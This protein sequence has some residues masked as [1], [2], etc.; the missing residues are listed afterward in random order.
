[1][2]NSYNFEQCFCS[3]LQ[4]CLKIRGEGKVL[5]AELREYL[6]EGNVMPPINI[7]KQ[8]NQGLQI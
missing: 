3:T 5:W 1:M 8:L 7:A 6:A 2:Y 4:A